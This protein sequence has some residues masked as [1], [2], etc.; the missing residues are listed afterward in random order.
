[1]EL[2]IHLTRWTNWGN[3]SRKKTIGQFFVTKILIRKNDR[4]KGRIQVL[5]TGIRVRLPMSKIIR[6]ILAITESDA[7]RQMKSCQ[8]KSYLGGKIK[9]SGILKDGDVPTDDKW[10]VP[11]AQGTT[12]GTVEHQS[13]KWKKGGGMSWG[14]LGHRRAQLFLG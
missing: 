6:Y 11:R 7:C 3:F 2:F 13:I 10:V 4:E 5:H 1:M 12:K 14:V 9:N 8:G